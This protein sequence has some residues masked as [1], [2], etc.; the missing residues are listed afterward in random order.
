M[1]NTDENLVVDQV[2]ENVTVM[3][4]AIPSSSG[5]IFH[6]TII[7]FSK[8]LNSEDPQYEWVVEFTCGSSNSKLIP[9][10]FPG[11]FVGINLYSKSEPHSEQGDQNLKDMLEA[12]D[13]LGLSWATDPDHWI[14]L[15]SGFNVVPH[16]E[17]CTY[18]S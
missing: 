18:D 10:L 15:D 2:M 16:G 4:H 1:K 11:D 6:T 13:D 14:G 3:N 12:I 9:L 5:T 17:N 8:S 7:A